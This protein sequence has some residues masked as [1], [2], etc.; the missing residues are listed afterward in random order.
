MKRLKV[1]N[2]M[3]LAVA[4]VTHR[5][6]HR[7]RQ[8]GQAVSWHQKRGQFGDFFENHVAVGRGFQ[9]AR[10]RAATRAHAFA[11]GAAHHVDVA[12]APQ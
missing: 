3:D 8:D 6:Q 9:I 1:K 11:Y 7:I 4:V 5:S 2:E 12:V 10:T